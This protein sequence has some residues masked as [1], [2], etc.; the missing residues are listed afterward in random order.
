MVYEAN[1][2][3]GKYDGL[4]RVWHENGQLRSKVNW[5]DG[6]P[7]GLERVWYE[8]GQLKFEEYWYK[9]KSETNY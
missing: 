3:D 9:V 2:K 6:E 7:Y 5:K 8:D 4:F 1:Y